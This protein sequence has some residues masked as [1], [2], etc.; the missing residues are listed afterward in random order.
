MKVYYAKVDGFELKVML[1]R[2]LNLKDARDDVIQQHRNGDYD[3]VV[4][5]GYNFDINNV[6][7]YEIRYLDRLACELGASAG[8]K[9]IPDL[10]DGYRVLFE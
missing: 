8:D 2:G 10:P 4:F 5:E 1:T 7:E 6:T 9:I 3:R